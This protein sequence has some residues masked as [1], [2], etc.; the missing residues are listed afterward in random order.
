[1]TQTVLRIYRRYEIA[2]VLVLLFLLMLAVL[3]ATGVFGY[4]LFSL[5][6]SGEGRTPDSLKL[7]LLH[8]AF[9][10]FLL[11]LIGIELMKTI[12][13]YLDEH[14]VHVEVVLEVAM[15]AVARHA[16]DVNYQEANPLALIGLASI[17]LALAA[18]SYLVRRSAL[19]NA[20]VSGA[21]GKEAQG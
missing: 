10:G 7:P 17:I 5:L 14:V 20:K 1:M 4:R 2:L 6:I 11:I 21:G 16:I 12:V 9:G 8:D 19:F 3:V 15:I 18:G 13:M